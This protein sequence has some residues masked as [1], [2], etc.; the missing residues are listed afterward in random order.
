MSDE[1]R[2]GRLQRLHRDR[3]AEIPRAHCTVYNSQGFTG[4]NRR[5][6]QRWLQPQPLAVWTQAPPTSGPGRAKKVGSCD[7][8]GHRTGPASTGGGVL[9]YFE[10]ATIFKDDSTQAS[11]D[12]SGRPVYRTSGCA[13]LRMEAHRRQ[14][15]SRRDTATAEEDSQRLTAL[16]TL[17]LTALETQRLTALE[18]LLSLLRAGG[19]QQR[20]RCRLT[21]ALG[22]AMKERW[23]SDGS[24]SQWATQRQRDDSSRCGQTPIHCVEAPRPS[25]TKA[26]VRRTQA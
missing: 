2:P 21:H 26:H 10:D 5:D 22:V 14:P 23:R 24:G 9:Q 3:L 20:S 4:Q 1:Y 18:A 11:T 25:P 7:K 12:R 8:A 13:S 6:D 17:R 15:R 19:R 16:E